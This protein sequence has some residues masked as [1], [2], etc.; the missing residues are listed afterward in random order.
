MVQRRVEIQVLSTLGQLRPVVNFHRVF[1][2]WIYDGAEPASELG[3][4]EAEWRGGS[5]TAVAAGEVS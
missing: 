1:R 2:E 4:A 5:V 3:R